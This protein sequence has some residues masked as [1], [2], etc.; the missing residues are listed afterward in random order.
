MPWGFCTGD[1]WFDLIWNLSMRIDRHVRKQNLGCAHCGHGR[2][3][4]PGEG[5][6]NDNLA[7]VPSRGSRRWCKKCPVSIWKGCREFKKPYILDP[8]AVQVKEKFGGLRFYIGGA[9]DSM[10]EE[11]IR[12][13]EEQAEKTCEDCGKPGK[14][15]GPWVRTLC[16]DCR[17]ERSG[18]ECADEV[19]AAYAAEED[20]DEEPDT[21]DLGTEVG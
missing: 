1:G 5:G 18:K 8:M 12:Q 20:E 16:Y 17:V 14:P 6:T 19:E 11:F 4:H 15:A 10:I 13:A 3:Y 9:T 7:G 2:L 21:N